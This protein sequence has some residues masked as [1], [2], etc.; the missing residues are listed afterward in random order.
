MSA[1]TNASLPANFQCPQFQYA[2]PAW[3]PLQAHVKTLPCVP[4]ENPR[5]LGE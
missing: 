3:V 5:V 4:P 2:N 1:Y